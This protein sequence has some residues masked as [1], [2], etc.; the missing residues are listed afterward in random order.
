MI[1]NFDPL[2][3]ELESQV[4]SRTGRRVQ[5]L[6]IELRPERVVLRGSASSYHVKQLAQQGVRDI[7]PHVGLE[8][9]I[10]VVGEASLAAG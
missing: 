3:D 10:T 6:A 7:L 8:N 4:R 2:Q 1:Q 9:A 5:N